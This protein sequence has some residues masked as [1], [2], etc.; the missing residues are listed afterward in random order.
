MNQERQYLLDLLGPEVLIDQLSGIITPERFIRFKD[1]VE[2]RVQGVTLVVEKLYDPLNGSALLRSAEAFGLMDVHFVAP[3]DEYKLSKKVTIGA[4]RWINIH[5]HTSTLAA[6]KTL[7]DLGYI[8]WATLPPFPGR[9]AD[10]TAPGPQLNLREVEVEGRHAL[11][12]GNERLGLTREAKSLLEKSFTIPMYGLS[13]SLNLSVSTALCLEH[14]TT[15]Y[16]TSLRRGGDLDLETQN[17]LLAR[18]LLE[19]TATPATTLKYLL[20]EDPLGALIQY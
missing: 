14:F 17:E 10:K 8:Q 3:T 5:Y 1:A 16:R 4:D 9:A 13:Q 18:Y 19:D 20:R 15:H 7:E 11:W 12:M 6:Y 2:S